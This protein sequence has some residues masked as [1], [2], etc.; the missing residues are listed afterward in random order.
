MEEGKR[1]VGFGKKALCTK[2][3]GKVFGGKGGESELVERV[4][5]DDGKKRAQW[6]KDDIE[7]KGAFVEK[8]LLRIPV[9]DLARTTFFQGREREVE[10]GRR[11]RHLRNRFRWQREGKREK[12]RIR[13]EKKDARNPCFV[14]VSETPGGTPLGEKEERGNDCR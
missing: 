3:S 9:S 5:R 1:S 4:G 13:R 2:R 8:Q 6:R 12:G 10:Q 11:K 7:K 14:I